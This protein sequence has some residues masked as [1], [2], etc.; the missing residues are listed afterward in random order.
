VNNIAKHSGADGV[1]I[2]LQ[3][4]DRHLLLSIKDNGKWKGNGKSSGT[5][6][7]SMKQRAAS[8]QGEVKIISTDGGTE[9]LLS[10]PVT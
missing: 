3:Q 5:G 2:T 6:M 1:S 10:I 9:V 8:V 4:N 7:S